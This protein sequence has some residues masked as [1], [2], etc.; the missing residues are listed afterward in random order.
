MLVHGCENENKHLLELTQRLGLAGQRH[1][2]ERRAVRHRT[3]RRARPLTSTVLDSS[4][5]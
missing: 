2:G 3:F 5:F 4:S 1:M